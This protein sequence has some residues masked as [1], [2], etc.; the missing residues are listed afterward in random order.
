MDTYRAFVAII[1][2]FVI[3]LGYQYFFVGFGNKSPA[4]VEQTQQQ[5]A[6][7]AP[8]KT[9]DTA[10]ALTAPPAGAPAAAVPIKPNRPARK[11]D[12][13]GRLRLQRSGR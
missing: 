3:L 5:P 9:A 10:P 8:G 13:A 6:V 12:R 4:P 2:S 7:V 1:I 11:Q